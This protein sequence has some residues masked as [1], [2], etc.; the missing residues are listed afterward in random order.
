VGLRYSE[1]LP[2]CESLGAGWRLPTLGE[3]GTMMEGKT[4]RS[5][6]K[7]GIP[8]EGVLFSADEIP[9]IDDAK[10]PLV[11]RI[12]DGKTIKGRGREGYARCAHGP[13]SRKRKPFSEP[14]P[15]L[16][17]ER[18]WA[19]ANACPSGSIARGTPGLEVS[20]KSELG[21]KNGQTTRWSKEGRSTANYRAGT[22]HGERT[23]WRPDGTKSEVQNYREGQFHGETTRWHEG[24]RFEVLS[25]QNG[26]LSGVTTRYRKDGTKVEALSYRDDKLHGVTTRWRKD[27]SKAEALSYRDGEL[28]GTTTRWRESGE[29]YEVLSY[30]S[31]ELHGRSTHW[32]PN[33][34]KS[35]EAIFSGGLLHGAQQ[36]WNDKGQLQLRTHYRNGRITDRRYY[37]RGK[38]RHGAIQQKH[39]NGV[40]SYVG[41][42]KK[43]RAIGQHYGYFANK[44]L[45]FKR[46]YNAKGI[47]HGPSADWHPNGR[48]HKSST[49]VNGALQGE[50]V[51]VDAQGKTQSRVI[52]DQGISVKSNP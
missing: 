41:V 50:Q 52:Y 18:W 19:K 17:G 5:A 24:A 15:A 28:F 44:R 48:T 20:C 29:K 10:Q 21:E 27:G 45:R 49:F 31:G 46:N 34:K 2:Y 11:M 37:D 42:F 39:G 16:M 3:L 4:M 25:Y 32:H 35:S 36:N 38:L 30:K 13:V 12:A 26:K 51:V 22:L 8:S 14:P 7:R 40:D 47:P 23:R 9:V 43:G 6:F 1:A 33:G